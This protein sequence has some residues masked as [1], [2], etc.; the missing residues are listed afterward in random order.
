MS[1]DLGARSEH[2]ELETGWKRLDEFEVSADGKARVKS[3][4]ERLVLGIIVPKDGGASEVDVHSVASGR[5]EK[6]RGGCLV[7]G[8]HPEA[9]ACWKRPSAE[10][11]QSESLFA[12]ETW[13]THQWLFSDFTTFNPNYLYK[14]EWSLGKSARK[15]TKIEHYCIEWLWG[16]LSL[17]DRV[18]LLSIVRTN[19]PTS[20]RLGMVFV[21]PQS[22]GYGGVT[23]TYIRK[24]KIPSHTYVKH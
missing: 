1:R 15:N 12:S 17:C 2:C 7:G 8:K 21:T 23:V 16:S 20:A 11:N 9:G 22:R 24:T 3:I 18:L 4:S 5:R 13:G 10:A 6:L 14:R 19:S